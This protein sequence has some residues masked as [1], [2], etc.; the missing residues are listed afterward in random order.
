MTE[1]RKTSRSYPEIL[2]LND[3]FVKDLHS[4][5]QQDEIRRKEL[6]D[7]QAVQAQVGAE[8]ARLQEELRQ[9]AAREADHV[10]QLRH[11]EEERVDQ[12]GAVSAHLDA[13]R[14]AVERYLQHGRASQP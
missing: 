12:L 5:I 7:L 6:E 13:L 1:S 9:A 2:R 14:S 8:I 10:A 4:L 11:L 3:E